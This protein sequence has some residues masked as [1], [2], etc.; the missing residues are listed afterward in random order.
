MF[1]LIPIQGSKWPALGLNIQRY[2]CR[3]CS[4]YWFTD[5]APL[6]VL[7]QQ[8]DSMATPAPHHPAQACWPHFTASRPALAFS[9]RFTGLQPGAAC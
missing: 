2:I 5:S 3:F 6:P 8:P 4:F 9:F 1:H 7:L